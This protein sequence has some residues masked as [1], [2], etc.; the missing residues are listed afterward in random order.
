MDFHKKE[1]QKYFIPIILALAGFLVAVLSTL[2]GYFYLPNL[3]AAFFRLILACVLPV[4]LLL[5]YQSKSAARTALPLMV[6]GA[7][8]LGLQ[9]LG[10]IYTLFST[11]FGWSFGLFRWIP[12][13]SILGNLVLALIYFFDCFSWGFYFFRIS[14]SASLGAV[15]DLLFL[16]SNLVFLAICSEFH[17]FSIL[18]SLRNSIY[19]TFSLPMT[20]LEEQGGFAADQQPEVQPDPEPQQTT[21]NPDSAATPP[22]STTG[23]PALLLTPKS[24]ALSLLLSFITCGIYY[25]V[26]MYGIMKRI[27]LL[28][29]D[30]DGCVGEFLCFFLIPFYNL[31]WYYTRAGKLVAG[32]ASYGVHCANN[33]VIYLLLAIFGFSIINPCLMQ[34]D[35]N[36]VANILAGSASYTAPTGGTGGYT[37]PAPPAPPTP[38]ASGA[39]AGGQTE[40]DPIEQL[41]KL[42]ALR[43][44]GAISEEEFQQKKQEL[45]KRI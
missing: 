32:A 21:Y 5:M 39:P 16:I 25:F 22:Q 3:G 7:V 6:L 17:P 4:I 15:S 19:R 12:G 45:L 33:G 14:I 8:L 20:N 43:K 34:N 35:L 29:R 40:P 26:W 36:N 13:S 41:Q 28:C 31:Y 10:T 9:L 42:N 44:S 38:P 24:I 18:N 27:R 11:I 23:I 30:Y 37:P 1:T 2:M